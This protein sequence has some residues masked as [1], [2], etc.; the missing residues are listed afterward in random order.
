MTKAESEF[1]KTIVLGGGCFWCTE[2]IF[3]SLEGVHT[4]EPGY[5]G[6]ESKNPTY[7]QVCT[8]KTGHAEVIQINFDP[9]I[10]SLNDLFRI[11]FL[12]HDPMTLNA[13]GADKGTQY[14]S[15][16]LV[17]SPQQKEIAQKIKNEIAESQLWDNPIV[18][19]IKDLDVFYPAEI[20]HKDYFER[21]P[22]APYCQNVIAP[23]VR[24]F[25]KIFFDKINKNA[26][27]KIN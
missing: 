10:I 27:A 24:K 21:N 19:E 18:T 7:E 15:I 12:I 2:A 13:Q 6:G 9:N 8:G 20:S 17:N 26:K 22:E 14:R 5:A 23:K 11:F 16:I 25:R 1:S 4:V 3:S